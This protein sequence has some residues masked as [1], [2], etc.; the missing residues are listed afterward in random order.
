MD[1]LL[2]NWNKYSESIS[3]AIEQLNKRQIVSFGAWSLFPFIKDKG[4]MC[5]IESLFGEEFVKKIICY[6]FS[7][8]DGKQTDEETKTVYGELSELILD[9]DVVVVITI[10][11]EDSLKGA[12][13]FLDGVLMLSDYILTGNKKMV[14][15]GCAYKPLDRIYYKINFHKEDD[16][17]ILILEDIFEKEM[18][19]QLKMIEVISESQRGELQ[20]E[21]H[22][23]ELIN[24]FTKY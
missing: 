17:D 4:I 13:D 15:K 19:N 14:S 16:I 6:I 8:W 24:I 2:D 21:R 1:S 11:N 22:H 20:I 3:L 5:F 7:C 9:D 10:E 12:T 23:E 18:K